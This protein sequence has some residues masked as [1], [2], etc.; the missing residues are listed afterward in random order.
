MEFGT[1]VIISAVVIVLLVVAVAA[2]GHYFGEQLKTSIP[3]F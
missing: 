1:Q 3:L 2:F